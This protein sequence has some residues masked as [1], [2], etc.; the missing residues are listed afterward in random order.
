ML[1]PRTAYTDAARHRSI[2]YSRLMCS[3]WQMRGCIAEGYPFMFGF[4]VYSSIYG[5]DGN[6]VV[7]LPL[8]GPHDQ[9]E[10][11][12]AIACVGYDDTRKMPDGSV[13]ALE[14][15]NSWGT[16][17]QD[18]GYF[19]MPYSYATDANLAADFWTIRRIAS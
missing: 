1:P 16:T 19:W 13:G 5:V 8:P 17:V 14:I 4:M 2:V 15:A 6:P 18:S 12:H 9:Q 3:L 10:G 11:G 7:D